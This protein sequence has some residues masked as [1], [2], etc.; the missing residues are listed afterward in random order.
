MPNGRDPRGLG[1]LLRTRRAG[2]RPPD[3][4]LSAGR[5][6][7]AAGLR[8]EE[9]AELANISTSYYALLEQGRPVRPSPEVLDSL[10]AA[11]RM[12]GADRVFMDV[13]A[14]GTADPVDGAGRPETVAV[15]VVELVQRLDP[16]PTFVKGRCWDVLAANAGAC[17]LFDDWP[18]RPPD[19]RNLVVWMFTETRARQVYVDWEDEARAMLGRYRLAAA[20]HPHDPGVAATTERLHAASPLV[21]H[22]WPM[23][24]VRQVGSGQKRLRHPELGPL[25]YSHVVLSVSD[26]PDQTLVTYSPAEPG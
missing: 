1:E 12:S 16:H 21:R 24:E 2:L 13:L 10:A 18:A 22:W 11:L 5:R 6:R 3:V 17:A 20:H 15:E 23:L 4:G 19:D 7:R 9:V 25:L 14:N 8:R 26:S